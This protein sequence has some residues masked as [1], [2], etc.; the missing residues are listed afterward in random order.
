M[1]RS[2]TIVLGL[3]WIMPLNVCAQS[4]SLSLAT[5]IA[6]G[7]IRS[8]DGATPVVSS[9]VNGKARDNLVCL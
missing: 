2:T 1:K 6:S 7:T 9:E 8:F 4:V 5:K 3:C